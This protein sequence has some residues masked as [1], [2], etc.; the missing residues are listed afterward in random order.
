[1]LHILYLLTL[2]HNYMG[3]RKNTIQNTCEF[4]ILRIPKTDIICRDYGEYKHYCD[5]YAL[6]QEFMIYNENGLS[7]KNIIIKPTAL[8]ENTASD[9]KKMA[10]F[11]YTF[12]CDESD[13]IPKL[14]QHIVPT[15]P[16]DTN[17]IYV[18]ILAIILLILLLLICPNSNNTGGFLFGYMAGN[19]MNENRKVSCE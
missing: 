11:Y 12:T 18:V 2:S 10:N 16:Y 4:D 8:W 1:M 19:I 3:D 6:P 9:K 14:I 15:K 17:P 13:K 5:H 7:G